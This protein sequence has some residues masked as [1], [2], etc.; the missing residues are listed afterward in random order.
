MWLIVERGDFFTLSV[1]KAC[2]D[3]W[4][5]FSHTTSGVTYKSRDTFDKDPCNY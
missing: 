2:H 1:Y 4:I 3:D 5:S